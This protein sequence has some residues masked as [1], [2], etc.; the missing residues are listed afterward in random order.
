MAEKRVV[1][2]TGAA[3]GIG[4]A[5][6]ETLARAG[7]VVVI[8]DR[9]GEGAAA[10]AEGIR[11]TG[12]TAHART[13][14]AGDD[15]SVQDLVDWTESDVGPIGGL[16]HAAGLLQNAMTSQVMDMEEHDRIWQVNYR[17]TYV[18]TKA[19][20]AR[21]IPRQAG[22][23]VT[24]G[25]IN[26]FAALPLPSYCVGK[27][28][29]KSLT[30]LLACEY[31]VHRIRVNG[32]APTYTITPAIQARIDSGHRD[33]EA[34]KNS[35]ALPMLVY[36]QHIADG[37]EFLLSDKA[38]AITGVMLPIDAGLLAASVYKSYVAPVEGF[39]RIGNEA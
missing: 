21:M 27:A 24:I 18:I 19:V 1:L 6:A 10:V 2:V 3:S 28:A 32:V 31:G 15:A 13:F 38:A 7:D 29:V 39:G 37:I 5:T 9:N 35:G 33:P 11:A 23:M 34:I 25:S 36:P 17:G 12:G 30:E 26:S 14:E 16:V 4:H 8:A 20:G 22:S